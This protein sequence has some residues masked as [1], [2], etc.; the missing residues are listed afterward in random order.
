MIVAIFA[1]AGGD[2]ASHCHLHKLDKADA[3]G[4]DPEAVY[5]R[6]EWLDSLLVQI[7][8]GNIEEG[9]THCYQNIQKDEI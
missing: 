5:A 3:T 1:V 6:W 7:V 9:A 4:L 8:N 2:S